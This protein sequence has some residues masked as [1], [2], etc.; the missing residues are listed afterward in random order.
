MIKYFGTDHILHVIAFDIKKLF[1]IWIDDNINIFKEIPYYRDNYKI[2]IET[3]FT[4]QKIH[5]LY[6]N[7]SCN[8]RKKCENYS[9]TSQNKKQKLYSSYIKLLKC[10]IIPNSDLFDIS[11]YKYIKNNNIFNQNMVN[12]I[13]NLYFNPK[14]IFE[15]KIL[16]KPKLISNTHKKCSNC[17]GDMIYSEAQTR[18]CDEAS[19][20]YFTCI[21]CDY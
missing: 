4:C 20:S 6:S 7:I 18:S 17:G 8:I 14:Y 1:E 13:K 19:T 5:N 16:R 9:K 15:D 3:F 2:N 11:S 12:Y 21:N 10:K